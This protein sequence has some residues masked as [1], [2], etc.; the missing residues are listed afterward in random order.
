VTW[1]LFDGTEGWPGAFVLTVC[2]C[3]L[4]AGQRAL[5]QGCIPARHIALSLGA[6]GI[7]YLEPNHWDI[8]LSYRYLHSEDIFIGY[9][10]QPQYKQG[11]S[12]NVTTIH[13][14]DVSLT[15]A[16]TRRLSASLVLPFI[17]ADGTNLQ[18]D[19]QRHTMHAGGLGDLRLLGN[20]WIW[21]PAK[22]PKGNLLL[23]LGFKAPTGD[24]GATDYF[25][26]RTGPVLRPVDIS[27]QPGDGGWGIVP[28]LQ[29]YRQLSKNT[30]GYLA[31][32]Y[33]INPRVK[34]GT[35]TL[36]STPGN[37][38][39]NSVPDQYQGRAG[40]SYV[41]WPEQGV[42]LSLGG[43]VDGIPV[44]DLI[45]GGDDGFRRPG[46]SI[47][48]EPALTVNRGKYTFSLSGPVAV[49]RNMERSIRDLQVGTSSPGGFADFLILA[50]LSRRF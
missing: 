27:I 32:F 23:S 20:A 39:I 12:N 34:N 40:L 21:D 7:S 28:E 42:A 17:D 25:Y 13:S 2:L 33:L 36:R 6:E 14:F 49:V 38:V 48:V 31:G 19:G 46:F 26:R 8:S 9:E 1:L 22:A 47:Y 44:R 35:E 29:A 50:S 5:A 10:E 24:Y 43:R 18:G 37:V 45:G 3:F 30:Y 41:V 16:F 11:G 4:G 15:Y